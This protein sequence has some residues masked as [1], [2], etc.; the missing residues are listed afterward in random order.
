[1]TTLARC[2]CTTDS[3]TCP[4]NCQATSWD[5]HGPTAAVHVHH[6]MYRDVHHVRKSERAL[7]P[8]KT[9]CGVRALSHQCRIMPNVPHDHRRTMSHG[10]TAAVHSLVASTSG[11]VHFV[12]SP[13][14]RAH[15]APIGLHWP[16]SSARIVVNHLG[17]PCISVCGEENS[18]GLVLRQLQAFKCGQIHTNPT[19]VCVRARAT[20]TS[21]TIAVFC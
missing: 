5:G 12:T 18:S 19:N 9:V 17:Q 11:S 1:M 10:P 15:K 3:A 4:T 7:T 2:P 14:E 6:C 13:V 21:L 16:L 20:L 8:R